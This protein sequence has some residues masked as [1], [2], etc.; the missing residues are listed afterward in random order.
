M[1]DDEKRLRRY[2]LK[3]ATEEELDRIE[4][5]YLATSDHSE[6]IGDVERHLVS[7]YV[8]ERLS[9]QERQAF[10]RN[11]LVTAERQ[12]QLGLARAIGVLA[13]DREILSGAEP[14]PRGLGDKPP[15]FLAGFLGWLAA[16]G[17]IMGL[18]AAATAAVL[19]VANVALVLRWRDQTRQTEEARHTIQTLRASKQEVPPPPVVARVFGIPVLKVEEGSL[20]I[21]QQQRLTF[22]LPPETP[23]A[24]EIPLELPRTAEG[25]SVD[26]ILSSSGQTLWSS[27]GITLRDTGELQYANL[28][29]PLASILPHLGRLLKLDIVERGH[30]NLA[31]F[32]I[33]FEK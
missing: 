29:M 21:G 25:A 32:Q 20:S 23:D 1:N 5:A 22:R 16:P 33:T 26:V 31:T 7:D 14:K 19:L 2:L 3:R 10:D 28:R 17:P 15:G 6:L 13:E 9:E 24:I 30:A 18:A 8:Q 4:D 12:E 27:Q 11:Y